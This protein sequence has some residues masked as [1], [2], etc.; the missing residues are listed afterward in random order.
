[1]QK[2]GIYMKKE[3]KDK[4]IEDFNKNLEE[5]TELFYQIQDDQNALEIL[6]KKP[7]VVAYLYLEKHLEEVKEKLNDT[8]DDIA[9]YALRET[10]STSSEE[11]FVW[12]YDYYYM[13][14]LNPEAEAIS[15]NVCREDP[16]G[17]HRVYLGLESLTPMNLT[18]ESAFQFE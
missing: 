4:I 16:K 12:L 11:P 17:T 6:R 1:M 18:K 13:N 14:R 9:E 8:T 10:Y 7:D 2:K 3:M 15:R 5:R